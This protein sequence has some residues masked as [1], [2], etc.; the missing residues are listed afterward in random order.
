MK[1]Y[2]K[3]LFIGT[4]GGNDIFSTIL[5]A[6]SLQRTMAWDSCAIAGVLSPFHIHKPVQGTAYPGVVEILTDSKRYIQN[7]NSSKEI[8]FIDAMVTSL[9]RLGTGQLTIEKVFGL[10]LKQGSQGIKQSLLALHQE[11]DYF[12]LV[13]VGGDILYRGEADT[14]I[15]SPM[16]D[17]MVLRG[18][19][20][21]GVPGILFE[22]GPGTDGELD[23][24][25]LYELLSQQ[26]IQTIAL[27]SEDIAWWRSYYKGYIAGIRPG[28]TV[29]LTI[30]AFY[31]GTALMLENFRVHNR[32]GEK[33]F[34]HNFN[35]TISASLCKNYYLLDPGKINNPFAVD[36]DS[37]LDWFR[38][39]QS[40]Q[41]R[42]NNEANMQYYNEDGLWWQILTPSPLFSI[43]DRV[44]LI[45]LGLQDLQDKNYDAALMWKNDWLTVTRDFKELS[46]ILSPDKN[47]IYVSRIE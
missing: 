18:F 33:K 39:T 32:L 8:S 11:Y 10:S 15:L 30:K 5:A 20:D 36:C 41:R 12:V 37:P 17:A 21:A 22:A 3:V 24:D 46:P 26:A 16:F 13:D 40:K 25:A 34:Y 45:L 44:S 43:A 9:T 28:R 38:L 27:E 14:H 23:H 35:Q 2:K 4:G 31:A 47:L 19:V 1:T 7:K 6:L 42:T 29:P